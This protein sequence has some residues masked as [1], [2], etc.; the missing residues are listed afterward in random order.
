MQVEI[1]LDIPAFDL[2]PCQW[3]RCTGRVTRIENRYR[4]RAFAVA[5]RLTIWKAT[6]RERTTQEVAAD[7]D[8]GSDVVQSR[9]KRTRGFRAT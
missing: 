5:G 8:F 1:R 9:A 2:I 3:L 4:V 7:F 6:E